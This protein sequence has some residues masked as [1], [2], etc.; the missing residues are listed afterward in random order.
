MPSP[1]ARLASRSRLVIPVVTA[2]MVAL[3]TAGCSG[4]GSSTGQAAESTASPPAVDEAAL[5]AA[6]EAFFERSYSPGMRNVRAVLISVGGRTVVE[7]YRQ[8][9]PSD[10]ADIASVTKSVVSTLVGIALADGSLT[11]VDQTLGDLLPAY[12]S[13][14]APDVAAI[15]LE[16]VLTMT[17]GLPPDPPGGGVLDFVDAPDWVR[18]ILAKGTVQPPGAGFAYSS[19]GSHLLAAILVRATGRP[20]LD[21]AR[22][23]LFD[24]LGI[25][26][27]PAA[28]PVVNDDPA[29]RAE[30]DAA[31]FAWPT[32]PQ[33][34]NL[35]FGHLKISTADMAKLGN[36]YL[37]NGR[38]DGHQ[39][40]TADWVRR[41]TSPLVSTPGTG[42][43]EHYGYQWWVTTAGDHPAF[44]AIGYG[45]QIIEVVPDLRLVVAASTVIADASTFD[46]RTFE[47]MV[48]TVIVPAL[49]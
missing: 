4:S 1:R 33:G 21:Y 11:S 46:A 48:A 9:S 2:A 12:R 39:V 38:W 35:G 42:I 25:D 34:I 13:E 40:V 30:Y 47:F 37:D 27:A 10:T 20:L 16:Q 7:Q 24:P 36:L 18:S 29:G 26:T 43:P 49:Q 23:K 14:M 6:V 17:A 3:S 5:G 45:G 22:D 44:E 19:A 15:T 41:A 28:Q 31:T 8:G 32:D